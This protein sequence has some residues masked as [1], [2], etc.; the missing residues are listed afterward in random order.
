MKI[1]QLHRANNLD[2]K[3]T[4]NDT[5]W[6]ILIRNEKS[7]FETLL[8]TDH[9][10]EKC[11]KRIESNPEDILVVTWWGRVKALFAS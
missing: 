2:A 5:Y 7:T 9:E 3:P 11:R 6:R 8:I 4:A 10:L 1:G